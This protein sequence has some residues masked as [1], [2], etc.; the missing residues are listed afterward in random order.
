MSLFTSS[1]AGGLC[2]FPGTSV[3]ELAAMGVDKRAVVVGKPLLEVDADTGYVEAAT[4]GQWVLAA[5]AAP[6]AWSSGAFV[7]SWEATAGPAWVADVFGGNASGSP[8]AAA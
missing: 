5:A 7:W 4:L 6:L 8:R 1:G 3:G 2:V